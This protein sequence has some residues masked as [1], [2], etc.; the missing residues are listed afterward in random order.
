MNKTYVT[1]KRKGGGLW[2]VT[3]PILSEMYV[4]Q[5]ATPLSSSADIYKAIATNTKN[6]HQQLCAVLGNYQFIRERT[7]A[8]VHREEKCGP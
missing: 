7:K 4:K 6:N 5:Q 1:I 2:H 8:L 3:C